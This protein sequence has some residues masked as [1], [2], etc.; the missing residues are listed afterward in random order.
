MLTKELIEKLANEKAEETVKAVMTEDNQ[1]GIG[2]FLHGKSTFFLP[3]DSLTGFES[4]VGVDE[5]AG[6]IT[7]E[8]R[9]VV[10]SA[11]EKGITEFYRCHLDDLIQDYVNLT[12]GK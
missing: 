9:K 12:D 2:L 5:T 1:K 3:M 4:D 7:M 10:S 11:V 6:Y 8:L